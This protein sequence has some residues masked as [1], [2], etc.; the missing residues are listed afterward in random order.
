MNEV[1]DYYDDYATKQLRVGINRRHLKI[2]D[3]MIEAGL[4][5]NHHVL[6]IG[7]GIGTVTS[8]ILGYV[9]KGH[10]LAIDISPRSVDIARQNL[11]KHSNIDFEVGNISEVELGD[12]QFDFVVLPDV[13]EHIP[14]TSYDAI[15]S[16]IKKA[17]RKGGTTLI[18]TPS[19]HFTEWLIKKRDTTLQ[20]IDHPVVLEDIESI[21]RRNGLII[22]L[23]RLY[24]LW[25]TA[26]DAQLIV[27]KHEPTD[28]DMNLIP[29]E[30]KSLFQ[31]LV[32]S[33]GRRVR[34]FV[35][36]LR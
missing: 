28:E 25:N 34:E 16:A 18:H 4:R 27:L 1:A 9:R 12:N 23:S 26:R 17:L 6:E 22:V 29:Y 11:R 20:I 24:S 5:S 36:Q 3:F 7:C 33:L 8:V 2:V 31:K 19:P 30:R 14:V 32:S 35:F 13:L 15:F 10:V 21:A